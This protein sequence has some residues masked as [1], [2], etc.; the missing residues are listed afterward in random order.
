LKEILLLAA[1]IAL[2]GCSS[3]ER[4][5]WAAP[6]AR[7][8]LSK[9]PPVNLPRTPQV[10][11]SSQPSAPRLPQGDF[12]AALVLDAGNVFSGELISS[13]ELV[14]DAQKIEF[15]GDD[16]RR[17]SIVHRLPPALGIAASRKGRGEVRL[18]ENRGPDTIDR[19]NIV[20]VGNDIVFGEVWVSGPMPI[21][22][23]LGHQLSLRQA[24]AAKRV[25]GYTEVSVEL[26]ERGKPLARL[27]VGRPTAVRT[28]QGT[29]NALVEISHIRVAAPG[30]DAVYPA[31][32]IL[33]V[34]FGPSGKP[35]G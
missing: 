4:S 25:E 33:R 32:F 13:G 14:V 18:R 16:K 8:G 2:C 11:D 26:F 5:A 24:T 27:P 3:G 7:V 23:D 12:P 1:T 34:W 19:T 9:N 29:V 35:P 30:S 10:P 21:A 28:S 20:R 31:M 6:P 22:V 17:I 15:V